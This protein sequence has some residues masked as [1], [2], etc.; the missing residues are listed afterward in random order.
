[1]RLGNIH[2]SPGGAT[3]QSRSVAPSGLGIDLYSLPVV[4]LGLHHRLISAAPPAQ[5][6]CVETLVGHFVLKLLAASLAQI[7]TLP[8]CLPISVAPQRNQR[9][10]MRRFAGGQV[11]SQQRDAEQQER[12]A[13]E[14]QRIG[15]ADAE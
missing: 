4:M 13:G 3:D 14:G 11:T 10:H 1:M 8:I 5:K 12:N 9:V 2:W 6:T 15:R 7:E